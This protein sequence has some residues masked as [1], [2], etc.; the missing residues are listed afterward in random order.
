[1]KWQFKIGGALIDFPNPNGT[2]EEN[3]RLLSQHFPQLR[4]TK[5]FL[6]DARAENGAMVLPVIAPPV[7]TN[8]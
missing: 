3:Q 1:M 6:E 2:L 8:G 5:V 4:W 7:K